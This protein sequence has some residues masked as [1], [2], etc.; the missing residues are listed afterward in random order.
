MRLLKA[1]G[2][3]RNKECSHVPS[4]ELIDIWVLQALGMPKM[5][6]ENYLRPSR[7]ASPSVSGIKPE[8]SRKVKISL[9]IVGKP[10]RAIIFRG[11]RD[12]KKARFYL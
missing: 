10:F 11:P 2:K 12:G 5:N 6:Q 1:K 3:A 9:R 7:A 4:H 8:S